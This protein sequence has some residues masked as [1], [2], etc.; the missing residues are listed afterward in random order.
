MSVLLCL[1]VT[2]IEIVDEHEQDTH[3]L[4]YTHIIHP[5]VQHVA[6]PR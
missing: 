4:I 1:F 2:H 3:K 6:F 5:F